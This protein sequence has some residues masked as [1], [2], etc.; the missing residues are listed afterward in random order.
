MINAE[1]QSVFEK[2][3]LQSAGPKKDKKSPCDVLKK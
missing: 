3:F 1:N 2:S